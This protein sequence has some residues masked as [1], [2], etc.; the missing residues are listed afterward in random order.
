[1]TTELALPARVACRSVE[2]S[3]ARL[4]GLLAPGRMTTAGR[5]AL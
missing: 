1:M 2:I 4:R 3:G 5:F